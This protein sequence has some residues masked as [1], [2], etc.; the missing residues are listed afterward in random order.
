MEP[1]VSRNERQRQQIQAAIEQRH[2][3]RALVLAREHLAEFPDDTIVRAALA[4][5]YT[6]WEMPRRAATEET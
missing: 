3:A 6:A 5:A 2:Y 4:E 1:T